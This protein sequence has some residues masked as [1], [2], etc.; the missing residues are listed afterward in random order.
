MIIKI[1]IAC[2][3]LAHGIGHTLFLMN[4]WGVAK[5]EAGHSWLLGG[6][7]RLGQTAEGGI[8][9]LW[10]VPFA[11][12]LFGTWGYITGQQGW[13][14]WLLA[15]AAISAVMVVLWWNG[16]N[17]ASAF[18][19]LAFNIVVIVALVWMRGTAAATPGP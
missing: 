9:L 16:I 18:F 17:T 10:L 5:T 11:G 2:A 19:A 14:P 4:A 1:V 8:G 13:Q 3:L 15:S 7:L 6:V 12:F